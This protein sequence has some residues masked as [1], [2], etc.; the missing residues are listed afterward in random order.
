MSRQEALRNDLRALEWL[1][2][3]LS[4]QWNASRQADAEQHQDERVAT[5]DLNRVDEAEYAD[6]RKVFRN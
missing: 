2:D 6:P 3:H 5:R 4:A 1:R